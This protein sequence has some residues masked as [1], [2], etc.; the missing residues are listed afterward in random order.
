MRPLA[1]TLKDV[2]RSRTGRWILRVA[3]KTPLR[4][5]L[6]SGTFDPKSGFVVGS[7]DM[8]RDWDER[9]RLNAKYFIAVGK[10]ESE[11]EFWKSGE[12]E[13]EAVLDGITLPPNARVLEIGCGIGR[14]LRPLAPLAAEVH[15]VDISEEMLRQ[16]SEAL[17]DF[18]NIRV[19]QTSGDLRMFEDATFDFCFSV[20]VFQHIASADAIRLYIREAARVLRSGG[21]FR[22]QVAIADDAAARTSEGG[23]WFG[24]LFREDE[25]RALL[26]ESG[27]EVTRI[28][29]GTNDL[30]KLGAFTARRR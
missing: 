15:G 30:W 24:V 19:H 2:L 13:I 11:E 12:R 18:P 23:T 21:V 1:H 5:Y 4:R 29:H 25:M 28:A 8:A 6:Y 27:F 14:L 16:A 17:R 20:L 3:G 26:D 7:G 22:F 9:A 10:D